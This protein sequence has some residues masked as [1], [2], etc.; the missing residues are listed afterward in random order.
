MKQYLNLHAHSHGS[1][2][3]GMIRPD[4]WVERNKELGNAGS[5]ITD[6][7]T[8]HTVMDFYDTCRKVGI[9]HFPGLEA[10]QAR[11]TRF[12]M[13][14]D[15]R[16]GRARSEWDQR[17]PHHLGIVAYNNVGYNNLIKI[18]SRSY[19]EGYFVKPRVDHQLISEHSEGIIILSGC[20]SGEVQQALLRND[21]E[22]ALAAAGKMQDIVGK[23]N[24]FIEVMDHFIDKEHQVRDD[25][26]RIAKTIG[27]KIVAT[28]DN[29]YTYK[30]Q[31]DAHDD[32]LCINTGSK[33]LDENRFRFDGDH[34][35]LK[36]YDEMAQLFPEEYL[37]NT[38]YVFEKYDLDIIHN[39]YHFPIF[40][41]PDSSTEEEFFIKSINEGAE[42]RFG[43]DWRKDQAKVDRLDYEINI[44]RQM[45]YPNYFL[46]VS[47]LVKWAKG[48]GQLVGPGRGSAA[49]SLV[50]YCLYITEVEPLEYE[51]SFER[52]LVYQPP[53]YEMNFP[54]LETV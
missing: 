14:E 23:D 31:A 12:D 52:F 11:K 50:S 41:T 20:L 26:I 36:S 21:Y 47:D 33:K 37:D 4:E 40:E 39:E 18:S 22:Y 1:L 29:H 42:K 8:L 32:M 15:E 51:L 43:P 17:G 24:Y 27:A 35:Y 6:H 16:S 34:Y 10:Y 25:L 3:D 45:G 28:C 38:M 19:T 48:D 5:C 13:D 53:S 49:G 30:H 9:K 46:V 44:I 54:E 2:L 7:G